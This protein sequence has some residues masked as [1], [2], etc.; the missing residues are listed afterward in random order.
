MCCGCCVV[1]FYPAVFFAAAWALAVAFSSF[2]PS[3]SAGVVV[4][5]YWDASSSVACCVF[6]APSPSD[7][8][9]YAAWYVVYAGGHVAEAHGSSEWC[10][11]FVEDASDG[12][13]GVW[14]AAVQFIGE[15]VSW[16]G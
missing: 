15:V 2:A 12:F 1:A 14:S 5:V 3:V 7:C 16:I 4:A 13:S 10:A 11:G 8:A 6:V 9:V